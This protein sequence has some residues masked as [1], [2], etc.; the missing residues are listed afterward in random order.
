MTMNDLTKIFFL[1]YAP[2]VKVG[3]LLAYSFSLS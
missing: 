3:V 2:L 1:N